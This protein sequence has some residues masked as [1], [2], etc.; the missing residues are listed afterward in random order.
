M[1]EKE[2]LEAFEEH[3]PLA[4]AIGWLDHD[5]ETVIENGIAVLL[6]ANLNAKWQT[7][8]VIVFWESGE[9]SALPKEFAFFNLVY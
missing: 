1:T 2:L 7:G 4:A 9:V 5:G 8:D 3:Q 6:R